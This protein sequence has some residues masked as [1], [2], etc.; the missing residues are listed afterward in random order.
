[1]SAWNAMCRFALPTTCQR[2]AIE[3]ALA[4]IGDWLIT[5][6]KPNLKMPIKMFELEDAL[7]GM[8]S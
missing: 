3:Q 5:K 7:K 8:G 6:M 1:M 4:C 2:V